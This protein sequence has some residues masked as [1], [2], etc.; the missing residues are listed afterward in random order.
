MWDDFPY[1]PATMIRWFSTSKR[2]DN[3]TDY[4][5]KTGRTW[6][7]TKT[8]S[9]GQYIPGYWGE[10]PDSHACNAIEG[11]LSMLTNTLTYSHTNRAYVIF[12]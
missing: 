11:T 8:T 4:N 10:C 1:V 2:F 6:C 9:D 3:C 12:T 7:A 5:K